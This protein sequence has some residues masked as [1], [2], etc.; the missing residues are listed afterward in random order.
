M[1]PFDAE[2]VG[3]YRAIEVVCKECG[4]RC[5]KADDMWEASELIHDIFALIYRSKFVVCDFTG[6]NPNVLYE[7]G[8]AHTLGKPVIPIA[9]Y[10]SDVP[11]DLRHHRYCRYYPNEQGLKDLTERVASRLQALRSA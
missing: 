10:D 2:F 7:T 3:V 4:L 11:F 5:K 8:I 6:K 1:I 9:Q